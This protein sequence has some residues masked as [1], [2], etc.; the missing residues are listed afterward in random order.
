MGLAISS[1]GLEGSSSEDSAASLS[2]NLLAISDIEF[3]LSFMEATPR[4]VG[5]TT[6]EQ[7]RV[8]QLFND[9]RVTTP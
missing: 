7:T 1:K 8:I 2:A 4:K 6:V 3:W 9:T 5:G